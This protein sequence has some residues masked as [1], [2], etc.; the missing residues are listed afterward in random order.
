MHY[1]THFTQ[2]AYEVN[3]WPALASAEQVLHLAGYVTIAILLA[4]SVY[5]G[6]KARA[7][8]GVASS[9]KTGAEGRT[10]GPHTREWVNLLAHVT[11][12]CAATLAM[13]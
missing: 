5:Q 7:G 4:L 10:P 1:L 11:L 9:E 8:S 13:F 12:A 3:P 2:K 6:R